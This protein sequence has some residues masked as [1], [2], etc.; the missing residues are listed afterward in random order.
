MTSGN[1]PED[2]SSLGKGKNYCK[3]C[4][5]ALKEKSEKQ[6]KPVLT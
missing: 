5:E 4:L 6:S 2:W 3:P 1:K